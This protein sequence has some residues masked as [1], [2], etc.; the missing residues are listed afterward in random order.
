[1]TQLNPP[2]IDWKEASEHLSGREKQVLELWLHGCGIR[3]TTLLLG[4]REST[5]RTYRQRIRLKLSAHLG[6]VI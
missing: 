3:R 5:V 2:R 6:D 1:M 4:L